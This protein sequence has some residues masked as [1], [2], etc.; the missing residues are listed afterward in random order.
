MWVWASHWP[1]IYTDLW[2]VTLYL[3]RK[4]MIIKS[5]LGVSIW[6]G[7]LCATT[8]VKLRNKNTTIWN[9][10]LSNN[11][12]GYMEQLARLWAVMLWPFQALGPGVFDCNSTRWSA[13]SAEQ[14]WPHKMLG[15]ESDELDETKREGKTFTDSLM[16]CFLWENQKEREAD[17]T[18]F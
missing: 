7:S 9:P 4:I 17:T 13:H 3:S 12:G 2:E 8:T 1:W 14:L 18:P 10:P 16:F 6:P 15:Y 5:A 11:Y